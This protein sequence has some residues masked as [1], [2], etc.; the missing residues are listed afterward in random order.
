MDRAVQK[1]MAR[2][3]STRQREGTSKLNF[4]DLVK[5]VEHLSLLASEPSYSQNAYKND[6]SIK[7]YL[8][9]AIGGQNDVNLTKNKLLR[10]YKSAKK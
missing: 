8:V 6:P 1:K 4:K 7:S 10:P 5:F 3:S 2:Q 9:K